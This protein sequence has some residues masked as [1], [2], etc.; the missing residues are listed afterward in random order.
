[1]HCYNL[2]R[3]SN[4][5]KTL[6]KVCAVRHN[7]DESCFS[8]SGWCNRNDSSPVL[9]KGSRPFIFLFFFFPLILINISSSCPNQYSSSSCTNHNFFLLTVWISPHYSPPQCPVCRIVMWG[10]GIRCR[11]CQIL[12]IL[13]IPSQQ[14]GKCTLRFLSFSRDNLPIV[15]VLTMWMR[16][17]FPFH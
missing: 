13:Q 15:S 16:M 2:S 7:H 1:M 4:T 12:W 9:E 10:T 11:Q 17:C 14:I 3:Y 5:L 6:F 8:I